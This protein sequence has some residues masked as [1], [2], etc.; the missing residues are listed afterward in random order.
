MEARVG[1]LFSLGRHALSLF[2]DTGDRGE[3]QRE[4]S[5]ADSKSTACFDY[6]FQYLPK[7]RRNCG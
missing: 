6:R 3:I 2:S 1:E 4:Q 5:L 7:N